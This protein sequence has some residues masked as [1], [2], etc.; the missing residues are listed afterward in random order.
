[1]FRNL[2][3]F[4]YLAPKTIED[5]IALL[6]QYGQKAE[7]LA[8][9]TD[10]IPL[11][12]WGETKPE[13]VIGLS[14]IPDLDEIQFIMTTGLKLGALTKIVE[15]EQSNII[16]EHYPVLARAASVLGSVEIRNRGT[17]GGNLCNAAP[18]AEMAPPL[19]VLGAKAVI[20]S[21]K[22]ERDIPL[23][24]FFVGPGK[25]VLSNGEILV[26]LEVPPMKSHSAGEYIKLGIRKAMDIAVVGVAALII[27]EPGNNTCKEA[28]LALGAV[29][30]TPIRAREAEGVLGGKNLDEEIIESAA[31]TASKEASPVTDIRAS[32][33][34]R[35]DMV[36][37]L[38]RQA[39]QQALQRIK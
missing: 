37:V 38:T 36:R 27:L 15:I 22:G 28:R 10:L 30:P 2:P 23:E 26:R 18:S 31:E 16:N 32:E 8:G 1:M 11:M 6:A 35:R 4:D 24:D 21:E 25:T 9:G 17:V 33:E 3:R 7:M 29:A 12:K 20:A 13:Y 39:I 34:Y 19:L 14:Q 5:C